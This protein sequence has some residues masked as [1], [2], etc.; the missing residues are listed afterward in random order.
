MTP[1]EL[2]EEYRAGRLTWEE[3]QVQI[4]LI[5][6]AMAGGLLG[7]D[8]DDQAPDATAPVITVT[9]TTATPSLKTR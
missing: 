6:A 2:L 4:A 9:A 8:D 1:E 7:L 5:A 3:Y